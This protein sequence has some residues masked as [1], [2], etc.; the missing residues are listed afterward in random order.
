MNIDRSYLSIKKGVS[1][2]VEI[3]FTSE[4]RLLLLFRLLA[5]QFVSPYIQECRMG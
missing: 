4:R 3:E 1:A 2:D 5:P